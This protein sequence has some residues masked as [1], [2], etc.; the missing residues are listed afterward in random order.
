MSLALRLLE[1]RAPK[2]FRKK[3]LRELFR[4]TALAFEADLP[5]GWG[6]LSYV[7]LLEAYAGFTRDQAG[8]VLDDPERAARA[9][10]RLYRETRALG[11]RLRRVL[12]LRSTRDV[13]AASRAVYAALGIDLTVDGQDGLVIGRCFFSASYTPAVCRLM[14]AA[15]A[16][17]AAGLSAGGRLV[18]IERLTEGA[19]ACR[20]RL[21]PGDA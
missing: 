15:D 17:A 1:V 12:G 7:S 8:R 20:A 18:F 5:P 10:A 21:G 13:L 9:E 19:A 16:G 6:R 14:S 11:E 4:A 3:V 2:A